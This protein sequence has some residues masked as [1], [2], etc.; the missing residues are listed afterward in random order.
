M[1][2][3]R[4]LI[5][6]GDS[7]IGG[8]LLQQYRSEKRPVI[9]T[10]RRNDSPAAGLLQLDLTENLRDWELPAQIDAAI[11]A[12]SITRIEACERDPE[13]TA[14]INVDAVSEL[15][16]RLAEAGAFVVFLSTNQVFDGLVPFRRPD[17]PVS[18]RTE[19][20]RQKAEAERRILALGESAAVVRLTKILEPTVPLFT[21]WTRSLRS[22]R[23]IEPFDD[24]VIAPVPLSCAVC[25]LQQ[26]AL[27]RRGGIYQVSGP[28]DISYAEIGHLAARHVGAS[29]RLV[30]PIS[31]RAT[32]RVTEYIPQ[33]T[34]LNI[35]GLREVPGVNLP[36]DVESTIANAL[37]NCRDLAQAG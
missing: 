7:R 33:H 32:Q 10:S 15:A 4:T 16:R 31:A 12:A 29:P 37:A 6:G 11:L 20:G 27:R 22:G 14:R 17:E 3:G 35:D 26:I 24:M 23:P 1:M 2:D 5:I 8:A 13:G 9:A 19:Y 36:P 18:P 28:R 34:T 21:E 25:I 30:R